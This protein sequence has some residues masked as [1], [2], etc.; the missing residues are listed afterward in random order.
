MTPEDKANAKRQL[1]ALRIYE[2]SGTITTSHKAVK[3]ALEK[4]LADADKPAPAKVAAP[5]KVEKPAAPK[6]E[7][8]PEPVVVAVSDDP[9]V[10][11]TATLQAAV[12]KITKRVVKEE[13]KAE[14]KPEE[15]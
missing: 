1:A 13:P 2:V 4:K 15:K 11:N 3:A 10:D 7:D 8:K 9:K 6:V 5:A 12:D 14:A